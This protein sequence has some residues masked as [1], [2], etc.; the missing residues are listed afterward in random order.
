MV[1]IISVTVPDSNHW[2]KI[3]NYKILSTCEEFDKVAFGFVG[4]G[5]ISNVFYFRK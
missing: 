3:E 4:N 5:K 1:K 2:G